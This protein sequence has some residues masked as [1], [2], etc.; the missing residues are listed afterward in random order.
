[1]KKTAVL[2]SIMAGLFIFVSGFFSLSRDQYAHLANFSAAL[3]SE[4]SAAVSHVSLDLQKLKADGR[5]PELAAFLEGNEAA[6]IQTAGDTINFFNQVLENYLY[7]SS[8]FQSETLRQAGCD[9]RFSNGSDLT[10]TT[11]SRNQEEKRLIYLN[12]ADYSPGTTQFSFIQLENLETGYGQFCLLT[13]N[14]ESIRECS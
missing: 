5:F 3:A 12:P 14:P 4:N 8:A 13:K 7:L 10:W 6:A 11:L 2:I 1:M 9:S